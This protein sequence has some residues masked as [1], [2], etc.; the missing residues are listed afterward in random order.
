MTFDLNLDTTDFS[1]D[2]DPLAT[3]GNVPQNMRFSTP[4]VDVTFKNTTVG[5][6]FFSGAQNYFAGN[7]VNAVA[8]QL[9]QAI[10]RTIHD[11]QLTVV[12]RAA[13]AEN[14]VPILQDMF[15]SGGKLIEKF[16]FTRTEVQ[17]ARAENLFASLQVY[18]D[19]LTSI[20]QTHSELM[21]N[22]ALNLAY[23]SVST[24]STAFAVGAIIDFREAIK[25][26]MSTIP[27]RKAI[28]ETAKRAAEG[29]AQA[30]ATVDV[31]NLTLLA[32]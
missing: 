30:Q 25:F 12:G 26:R 14:T 6:A 5:D 31:P 29:K 21:P 24:A 16:A 28:F 2:V 13:I 3:I 18:W 8:D 1:T 7:I 23:V 22:R 11:I 17:T 32:I 4:I 19:S 27:S 20:M 15:D 9:C 10:A